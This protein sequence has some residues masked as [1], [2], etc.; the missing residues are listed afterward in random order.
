[1]NET[2][3]GLEVLSILTFF[4]NI[5]TNEIIGE[6]ARQSGGQI[7]IQLTFRILSLHA[8]FYN[9]SVNKERGHESIKEIT[10]KYL[11]VVIISNEQHIADITGSNRF[12]CNRRQ[13]QIR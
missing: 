6:A 1:M 9:K 12:R 7:A 8:N 4:E 10:Y 5:N 2:A 3:N 11:G 13:Q